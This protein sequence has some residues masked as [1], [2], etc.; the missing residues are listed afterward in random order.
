MKRLRKKACLY[1]NLGTS[2]PKTQRPEEKSSYFIAAF[3]IKSTQYI[4]HLFLSEYGGRYSLY[5]TKY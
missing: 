4:F 1:K 5:N 2:G 3:Y